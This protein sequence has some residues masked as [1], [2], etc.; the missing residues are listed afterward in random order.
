MDDLVEQKRRSHACADPSNLFY[1]SKNIPQRCLNSATCGAN[2]GCAM[3]ARKEMV[4][5]IGVGPNER[6]KHGR[7]VVW[8]GRR[9]AVLRHGEY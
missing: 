7:T 4:L 9:S 6:E 2:E 8:Q 1:P 3:L 5:R